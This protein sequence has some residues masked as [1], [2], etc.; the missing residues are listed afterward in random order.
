MAAWVA[1][2][3]L[4][5][6]VGTGVSSPSTV[7]NDLRNENAAA[8]QDKL[9]GAK[10]QAVKIVLELPESSRHKL[11]NTVSRYGWDCSCP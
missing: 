3:V 8:K 4:C 9:V 11:L 1:S 7:C 2:G 10:V 5:E 6:C